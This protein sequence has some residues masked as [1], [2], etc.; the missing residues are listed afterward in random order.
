MDLRTRTVVDDRESQKIA[1]RVKETRSVESE[2]RERKMP[3]SSQGNLL[4]CPGWQQKLHQMSSNPWSI[5]EFLPV[6]QGSTPRFHSQEL[7]LAK[8]EPAVAQGNQSC[9][10]SQLVS[11]F[12]RTW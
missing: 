10:S 2:K 12:Q 8:K 6:L 7:P 4:G 11:L 9:I 1:V 3:H 5:T